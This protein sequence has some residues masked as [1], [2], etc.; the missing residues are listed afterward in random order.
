MK[1]TNTNSYTVVS[2]NSC[3]VSS[4]LADSAET[5]SHL[6]S[7]LGVAALADSTSSPLWRAVVGGL[8]C[9]RLLTLFL[10]REGSTGAV[11]ST[12]GGKQDDDYMY[13]VSP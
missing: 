9:G 7:S 5:L 6:G 3:S 10:V 11:G 1:I 2:M 4:S 12:A 13:R 8:T